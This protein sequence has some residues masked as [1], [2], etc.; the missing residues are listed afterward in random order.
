MKKKFVSE[1]TR[2]DDLLIKAYVTAIR[3]I[4]PKK[5]ISE[6][7]PG[8]FGILQV[9]VGS[10]LEG[11]LPRV[12]EED[13]NPIITIKGPIPRPEIGGVYFFE[14]YLV[15]DPRFG[16]QYE[17]KQFHKIFKLETL[18]QKKTFITC[19]F[20]EN[21]A[22]LL[23]NNLDD[24][25]AVLENKDAQALTKI[26]GIGK[27][28][29][30]SLIEL[31]EK[32][33]E[34]SGE[35]VQLEEYGLTP[36][37]ISKM[38]QV[39]KSTDT[40]LYLLE[41]NPYAFIDVIDGIGWDRADAMALN[42]GYNPNGKERIKAY[43]RY[44]LKGRAELEGHSWVVLDELVQSIFTIAP[45]LS[46]DVLRQ[47]L[48][49]WSFRNTEETT[50]SSSSQW[51]YYDVASRRIGL[52]YYRKLEEQIAFHLLRLIRAASFSFTNEQIQAAISKSEQ[53]KGFD[54]TEEQK[55]AISK[56]VN[57]NVC[58]IAGSAGCGKST[59]MHPATLLFNEGKKSFAQ[60]SLSGKAASNL[61]E[62]T[63][64]KGFTIHRLLNYNGE[65]NSFT[66]NEESKLPYDVI[67]LDELSLV[68]GEIF[69]SLIK[70]IPSGSKLIMLGDP[71]Q[72]EAIGLANLLKDCILSN[73]IPVG[74]LTKIHRQAARSGI[75]TESLKISAGEQ[76]APATPIRETRGELQD[77][78]ITT[79]SDSILSHDLIIDEY[80][81]LFFD[82]HIPYE[83]I[84]VIVPMRTRGAISCYN[85]NN[86]IQKIVN[87]DEVRKIDIQT[88][89]GGYSLKVGDKILV[90]KNHYDILNSLG[91]IC[92]IFNGNSG[93]VVDILPDNK[94]IKINLVQ[95]GEVL[96]PKS[97]WRD[98]ELGYALTCH[99]AQ[100][101]SSD[102]VIVGID[103]SSY[104]LLSK[105]WVYTAITRARDF[106]SVIGQISAL[107]MSSKTSRVTV[108]HTWLQELL[109]S[110]AEKIP[111]NYICDVIIDPVLVDLKKYLKEEH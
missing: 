97:Y 110:W 88:K 70:A 10:V 56:C 66:Y 96:I 106:C 5:D 75:I 28:T 26:K 109:V 37:M 58:I 32:N 101:S 34:N 77:L 43:I 6:I 69:L 22:E 8:E 84:A 93:Y 39:F 62:I 103:M 23:Y 102:Y 30:A 4:F 40:I 35:I 46:P 54:Y 98:I 27:L 76:I 1:D 65:S 12:L 48:Q 9:S 74:R 49:E 42:K 17:I 51:L 71:N 94:N 16:L 14:G 85:L 63:N 100:G 36:N 2:S 82:Y 15:D 57:N 55:A 44:Y 99:K 20:G 31:Y 95:Q 33:I 104:T 91:E 53:I 72:L 79:Y 38:Q 92:P 105:E 59:I 61:S 78:R 47:Y 11:R 68:G 41:H 89:E 24:P 50:T 107:K 13:R 67:I 108:K 25:V 21:K 73:I 29:A 60:C 64:Q 87:P 86:D 80:R 52:T 111:V 3:I 90:V 81:S 83:D 19:L 45:T 7:L 18:E